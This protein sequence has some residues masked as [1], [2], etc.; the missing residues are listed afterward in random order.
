[1]SRLDQQI[2]LARLSVCAAAL[3]WLAAGPHAANNPWT[4]HLAQITD[5]LRRLEKKRDAIV[6][7]SAP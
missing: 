7:R 2:E 6:R 3:N 4:D 1:M 5:A